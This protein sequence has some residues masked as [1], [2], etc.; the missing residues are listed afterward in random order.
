MQ[1][2]AHN[3]KESVVRRGRVLH[4]S[5]AHIPR[6]QAP[7]N[8]RVGGPFDDCAAVGKQRHLVWF[9]PELEDELVV[10]HHPVRLESGLHLGEIDGTLLLVDLYGISAA[11]RDVGTP[12]TRQVNKIP[13]TAG[14]ATGTRIGSSNFRA[15]VSPDIPRKEGPPHL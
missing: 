11:H 5:T 10:T 3:L 8:S 14:T 6:V 1:A 9:V 15:L 4:Q 7:G 12:F 2:S 13:H